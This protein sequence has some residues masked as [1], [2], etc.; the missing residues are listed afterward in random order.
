M[1]FCLQ[2]NL[3]SAAGYTVYQLDIHTDKR[4][5]YVFCHST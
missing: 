5:W 3:I 4:V 2:K 1:A